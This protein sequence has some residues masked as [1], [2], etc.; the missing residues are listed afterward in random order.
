MEASLAISVH[1]FGFSS[2]EIHFQGLPWSSWIEAADESEWETS[3][4]VVRESQLLAT[5]DSNWRCL[6]ALAWRLETRRI[7][8][9]GWRQIKAN[10]GGE[11]DE[12]QNET[13]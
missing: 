8:R 12:W 11:E 4:Y 2:S 1:R 7:V 3:N 10:E 6:K 5:R 9:I 13:K